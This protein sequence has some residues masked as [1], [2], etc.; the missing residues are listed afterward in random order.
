M[1][2][3]NEQEFNN[4][5]AEFLEYINTTP[6]D[7]DFNIYNNEKGMII[8][9]KIYTM[10]ET[11]SMKFHSDWNWIMVV[12][13]KIEALKFNS[14][15]CTNKSPIFTIG[16]VWSYI[17]IYNDNDKKTGNPKGGKHYYWSLGEHSILGKTRKEAVVQAIWEFFQWYN[18][19]KSN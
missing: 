13:E 4:L 12:I 15:T 2:P 3:Y 11:M 17:Y 18:Q 10:L 9:N 7:S 8:G 19:Y 5:C 16:N 14:E 6:T 1:K